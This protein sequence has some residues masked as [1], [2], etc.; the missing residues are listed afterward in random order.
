MEIGAG[1]IHRVS[2]APGS[3]LPGTDCS[4]IKIGRGGQAEHG[5]FLAFPRACEVSHWG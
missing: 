2:V 3:H 4:K 1:Q 5:T